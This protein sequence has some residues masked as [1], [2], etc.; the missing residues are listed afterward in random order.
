MSKPRTVPFESSEKP[1]APHPYS[2]E[3]FPDGDALQAGAI[4]VDTDPLL[5]KHQVARRLSVGPRFVERLITERRIDYVKVGR[6]VRVP[7]SAVNRFIGQH[8]IA[9]R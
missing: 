8:T 9:S 5:D 2:G 6:H 1:A 7:L 4:S 3:A